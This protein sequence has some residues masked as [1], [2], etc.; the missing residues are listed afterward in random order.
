MIAQAS[1]KEEFKWIVCQRSLEAIKSAY[2]SSL[3]GYAIV[4]FK[5]DSWTEEDRFEK[6]GIYGWG[7]TEGEAI[8]M[9]VRKLKV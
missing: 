1:D 3:D 4:N 2:R 8:T 6:C 7:S 5:S 9:A